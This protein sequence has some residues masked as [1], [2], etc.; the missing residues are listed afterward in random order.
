MLTPFCRGKGGWGVL[1]KAHDV[2]SLQHT[3]RVLA[4]N[5]AHPICAF[6]G[7]TGPARAVASF[8]VPG[9]ADLAALQA[10]AGPSPEAVLQMEE[11]G[12]LESIVYSS[13][14]TCAEYQVLGAR[15]I[16]WHKPAHMVW[17]RGQTRD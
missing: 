3:P 17:M 7:S 5:P 6:P 16:L 11:P 14:T 1:P 2:A 15:Q 9:K 4:V 13:S 10:S 8:A 12:A